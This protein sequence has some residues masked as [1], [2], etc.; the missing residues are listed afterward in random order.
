MGSESWKLAAVVCFV[1]G[2]MAKP[3]LVTLPV[4]LLLLDDW[5]L[6]R[7]D[8]SAMPWRAGGRPLLVEKA[9]FIVLAGLE[10]AV[11]I[12]SQTHSGAVQRFDKL[13]L[14]S[15]VASAAMGYVEYLGMTL[16]PVNLTCFYPHRFQ[17]GLTAEPQTWLYAQAAGAA[18]LVVAI[19]AVAVRWRQRLP[20]LYVG[21]LWYVVSLL[22]V[23]GLVQVGNQAL[24]DR[25]LYVPSIGLFVALC[26]GA[27]D[28]AN[29]VCTITGGATGVTIRTPETEGRKDRE[30]SWIAGALRALRELLFNVRLLPGLAVA[31][32]LLCA[33]ATERQVGYWHDSVALFEH[34][35]EVCDSRLARNNLATAH[36][37]QGNVLARQ[38]RYA[39]AEAEY[40]ASLRALPHG[41]QVMNHLAAVLSA[42]GND[43]DAT[44]LYR[45]VLASEPQYAEAHFN[46]GLL[47][48]KQQD[49]AAAREH[50][51]AAATI[52]P[53]Y[54]KA[55]AN[56]GLLL[57]AEGKPNE[58]WERFM[59]A[60]KAEAGTLA[61][62]A[63]G[64]RNIDNHFP[65]QAALRALKR[66]AIERPEDRQLKGLVEL[67][68]ED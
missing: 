12:F 6:G 10:C 58:A 56:L 15:R 8:L 1:L 24:A 21:W 65:R 60:D 22:P 50:F 29:W 9:S 42:Q 11:T 54:A 2:L 53:S 59:L 48:V 7:R 23:I 62:M 34:A 30:D 18:M 49:Y 5:P 19:T 28:L 25:Y 14:E 66:A 45:Q 46:W 52:K 26:W 47:L 61:R 51:L 67:L 20:Y 38:G 3:M 57:A 4:L 32:V 37:N 68:G 17:A 13:P 43:A 16:W 64:W 41:L 36:H 35:L 40:R 39:E 63:P 44:E 31:S 55:Q 27:A 33:L